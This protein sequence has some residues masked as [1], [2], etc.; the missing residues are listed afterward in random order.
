MKKEQIIF[1]IQWIVFLDKLSCKY[2]TIYSFFLDN[3]LY[4]F[5]SNRQSDNENSFAVCL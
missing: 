2:Y 1:F 3:Y 4:F 5:Y